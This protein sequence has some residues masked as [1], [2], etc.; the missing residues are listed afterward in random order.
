VRGTLFSN[1]LLDTEFATT[2]ATRIIA[3]TALTA[4]TTQPGDRLVLELGAHAIAPTV[5]G[6]YT[7]RFGNSNAADF[8]LTSALT[9]DLNPWMELSQDLY[10]T[11]LNNYQHVKV[12]SGMSTAEKIR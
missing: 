12:E 10:G 8:A 3:A 4:L 1:F 2:T 5:A 6:S 11:P 9:T 7:M